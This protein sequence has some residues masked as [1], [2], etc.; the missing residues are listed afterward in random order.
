M[1]NL[2]REV[3]MTITNSKAE[4]WELIGNQFWTIGRVAA[5]PSDRENDIFLENIVPGSTVA[6]IGASTRFLIEKALERGASVTVFDFSQRM[7]DDLAEALADRCVT[8]DLLDITAEIPKELAGHFDFVLNDR[9]INR[10]TTEEA[11]RACLGMLSLV[12]SG[13]VR[14]SVKL[15]FYDI[16]LK[17]IEYGEQSGTLAK[18]FDPSDKTFHF[19]EA[20]DVLDRALVPH[21]LIDK[22]TLLEWYRRRGKETRFDDEDVRALLSHDVVNARGYVTLEKAVELPDAPNTMLYQFSRRAG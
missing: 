6:V 5:R 12:G 11:R 21:G 9:L 15:G 8:I 7:C 13:T 19:R 16:D 20:G 22:P 1:L 10:F 3:A 4:A 17:L 14:A 2:L 18:F